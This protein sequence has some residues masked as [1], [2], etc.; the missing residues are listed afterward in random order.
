MEYPLNVETTWVAGLWATDRGSTAKG[1]VSIKNRNPVLLQNFKEYSLKNFDISESRFRQ[2]TTMGYSEGTDLYFTRLPV[3]R[4]LEGIVRNRIRLGVALA[5]AYLVGKLDG[6]GSVDY[7]RSLLY[8]GYS[9][10]HM[11]DATGDRELLTKLGFRTSI[12]PSGDAVKLRVLT[13]RSFATQIM[14]YVRHPIKL[15]RLGW[16]ANKRPW[17]SRTSETLADNC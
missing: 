1:V 17:R 16:L 13:P 6:D 15:E 7:E 5:L 9:Q 8:Y 14:P 12:G 3:R 11:K 4:F 2:R 10:G